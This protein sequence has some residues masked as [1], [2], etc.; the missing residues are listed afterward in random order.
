MEVLPCADSR[1]Q[2][3]GPRT[4]C[5]V[6]I[7]AATVL[8]DHQVRNLSGL[9]RQRVDFRASDRTD[10]PLA[11]HELAQFEGDDA[12]VVR[13]ATPHD[14]LVFLEYAEEVV[15]RRLREPER[16]TSSV[17]PA[18]SR[19]LSASRVVSVFSIDRIGS[20]ACD[21]CSY[22]TECFAIV[23]IR[24]ST[25]SAGSPAETTVS[26]ACRACRVSAASE[27]PGEASWPVSGTRVFGTTG[28]VSRGGTAAGT[29]RPVPPRVAFREAVVSSRRPARRPVSSGTAR[30]R[31]S[32]TDNGASG[33]V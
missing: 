4:A 30:P 13:S 24:S 27:S 28:A 33:D 6:E 16:V 32:S 14:V 5:D 11:S 25:A 7:D 17:T 29:L 26:R 10:P 15:N 23:R 2:V 1:V 9:L 8:F 18:P 12:E 20:F 31:R 19:S 21:M 3:D 22:T